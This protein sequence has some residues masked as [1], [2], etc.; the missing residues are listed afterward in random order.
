MGG[1]REVGPR[2]REHSGKESPINAKT[3]RPRPGAQAPGVSDVPRR[4]STPIV[5]QFC[6]GGLRAGQPEHLMPR[7]EKVAD[8]R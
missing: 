5:P 7:V 2:Q 6:G 8:Y 3:G 1:S 4:T